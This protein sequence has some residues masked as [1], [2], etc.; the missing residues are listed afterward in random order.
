M[1]TLWVWLV[2]GEMEHVCEVCTIGNIIV[3]CEKTIS[4]HRSER[5]RSRAMETKLNIKSK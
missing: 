2:E 3:V 5:T 4:S 1:Q